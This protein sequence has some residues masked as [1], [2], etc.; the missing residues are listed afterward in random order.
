MPITHSELVNGPRLT[1]EE[2]AAGATVTPASEAQTATKAPD[3]VNLVAVA[4]D[5][6]YWKPLTGKRLKAWRKLW[7]PELRSASF[8]R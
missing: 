1:A 6:D 2:W 3:E 7:A 5:L 4:L 8:V